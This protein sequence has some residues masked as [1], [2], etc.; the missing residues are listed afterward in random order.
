MKLLKIHQLPN[1]NTHILSD[2]IPGA[3]LSQGGLIFQ[4]P[5]DRSHD[6][7]CP[8]EACDD[9]SRHVHEDDHEAFVI[10]Q[11]KACMEVDGQSHSV[12]AG[13]VVICEPGE[14]HHLVSDMQDPCVIIYLHA[15][16]TH[17]ND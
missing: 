15:S 3:Y 13:D 14:D 8:C 11:G 16:D 4:G 5:G 17:H 7:G 9:Q 1:G 2:L 6:F 12:Q 10:L